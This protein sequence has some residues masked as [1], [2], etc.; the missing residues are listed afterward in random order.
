MADT[1]K[2][3][4]GYLRTSG[5]ER[6]ILKSQLKNY[7]ENDPCPF[8]I[9]DAC[10]VHPMRPIACRQFIVFGNPCVDGEGPYYTRREDVLSPI[11]GYVGK[12]FFI[13]L[14][15]YGIEKKAERLKVI[16]NRTV[17]TMVKLMQ[18]CNWKSLAEKMDNFE[19][20]TKGIFTNTVI[21]MKT[22]I[23]K[24]LLTSLC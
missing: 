10:S 9:E 2:I 16:Q 6:E 4:A 12:A 21:S 20:N 11:K 1:K 7:T 5:P 17:H 18:T 19:R 22:L 8:L 24:S 13:M 15:F 14:P 23:I 3:K